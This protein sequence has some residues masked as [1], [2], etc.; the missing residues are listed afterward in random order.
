MVKTVSKIYDRIILGLSRKKTA[1]N[2]TN[3]VPINKKV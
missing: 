1:K 2:S 3:K